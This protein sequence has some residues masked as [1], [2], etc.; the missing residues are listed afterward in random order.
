MKI[1]GILDID[2]VYSTETTDKQYML[3]QQKPS[4]RIKP[5]FNEI[6]V[7]LIHNHSIITVVP[8]CYSFP[9]ISGPFGL[10]MDIYFFDCISLSNHSAAMI[11][12]LTPSPRCT[13]K[14]IN[15]C[16][17][18]QDRQKFTE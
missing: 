17:R 10:A 9:R 3:S 11:R 4:S 5:E 8:F 16:A 7:R 2:D 13:A 1:V 12:P 15:H 18:C 14:E 6:W